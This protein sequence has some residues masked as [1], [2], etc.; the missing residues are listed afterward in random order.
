LA[1]KPAMSLNQKKTKKK[2]GHSPARHWVMV[3]V[4]IGKTINKSLKL[5]NEI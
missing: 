4:S 2:A 5:V 1:V 3:G